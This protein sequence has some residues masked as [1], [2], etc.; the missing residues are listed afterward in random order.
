MQTPNSAD[1]ATCDYIIIGS[2]TA[3]CVLANRLSV[4][5]GV[6]VLLLEAGGPYRHPMLPI[7]M[8]AG[9]SYFI[10]ATNWNYESAPEPHLGNR[11]P[12][13]QRVEVVRDFEQVGAGRTPVDRLP[14]GMVPLAA[15][16]TAEHRTIGHLS[17]IPQV[18]Q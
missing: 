9:L 12:V 14:Q 7:P 10:K 18:T 15:S 11:R 6:S 16:D 8:M 5:S 1:D 2:G 4:D 13:G 3:G 17:V